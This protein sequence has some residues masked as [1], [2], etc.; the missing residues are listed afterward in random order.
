MVE[1][2][3]L[4]ALE[5]RLRRRILLCATQP[6]ADSAPSAMAIVLRTRRSTLA[7]RSRTSDGGEN[8]NE[9]SN[10]QLTNTTD[11]AGL[12]SIWVAFS[13]FASPD[14]SRIGRTGVN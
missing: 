4:N 12:A 9:P 14:S 11:Q 7:K 10:L 1:R 8:E 5:M 3:V 13:G 6:K 2:V